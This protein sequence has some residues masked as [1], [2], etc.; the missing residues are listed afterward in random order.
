MDKKLLT[1]RQA[2]KE[3]DVCPDTLRRWDRAGKLKAMRHPMNNYR[4]YHAQTI[5][6]LKKKITG[7]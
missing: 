4:V 2:A 3:L 6:R 7:A 5:D 1:V